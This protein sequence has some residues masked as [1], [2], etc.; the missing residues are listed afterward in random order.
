MQ[1]Q[2]PYTLITAWPGGLDWV[3]VQRTGRLPLQDN[4][5]S[6][7]QKLLEAFAAFDNHARD[8]MTTLVM[9]VLKARAGVVQSL[10]GKTRVVVATMDAYCKHKAGRLGGLAKGVLKDL[11]TKVALCD[12]SEAYHIDQAVAALGG[13]GGFETVIFSA[14]STSALRNSTRTPLSPGVRGSA[15]A[16]A[17]GPLDELPLEIP[18]RGSTS[19]RRTATRGLAQRRTAG[20][21]PTRGGGHSRSSSKRRRLRTSPTARGADPR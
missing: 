5:P 7:V 20:R 21:P 15:L 11:V 6:P 17:M 12:E 14:T 13:V 18:W 10:V 2:E 1:M 9:E 4:G 8:H 19:R 16:P 3:E